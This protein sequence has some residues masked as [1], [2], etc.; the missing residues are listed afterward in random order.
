LYA[1]FP[2][3]FR[4]FKKHGTKVSL[5]FIGAGLS[6]ILIYALTCIFFYDNKNFGG[7]IILTYAR[8]P[9]FFIGAIFGHWAKEGCNIILTNKLKIIG[10]AS[11]IIAT[12]ILTCFMNFSHSLLQTCSLAYL[13]YIIITPVL[14]ILL[15]LFFEKWSILDKIF[16]IMGLLSLELYLCHVYIYKLFFAFIDYLDKDSSNILIML[17]SF[18]AAYALYFINRKIFTKR[19]NIRIRP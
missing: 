3:Y 11:A 12:I 5:I 17:L 13:P 1:I 2:I 15:A 16:T 18:L 4:L 7:M 9:T 14:C 8:I 19:T 6:L 10:I